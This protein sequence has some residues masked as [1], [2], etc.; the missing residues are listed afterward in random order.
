MN[1]PLFVAGRYLVSRRKKNFINI[2]SLL[3]L[4]GVAFSTA[5]LII[6]LSIFN[7]LES[8]LRSLNNSFDPEIKIE[9]KW[10][11]SFVVTDSLLAAIRQVEGVEFV[12]EVIE[13]YVYLRYRDANQ[14]VTMKGVSEDFLEQHRIDDKIVAGKL[15]LKEQDV[16]YAIIGRGIQYNL[17]VAI[18]DNQ[19]ALQVYY[20]NNVRT[21][22]VDPSK[23]YSRKSIFAGAAFSIVQNFDENYIVVPLDFA[24]ELLNMGQRRTALEVKTKAGMDEA[25]VHAELKARLGEKFSVLNHEEQHKDLYRLLKME[26]LFTFLAFAVLLGIS[27][28]NIFFTLM[29]LA[30]DKK[31][32]ISVLAAMGAPRQLIR[33]IFLT[34][35][36]IIA[37]LGAFAGLVLGAVFCW[38][39]SRYGIISMGMETSV[40]E[41]YP[42]K[43]IPMD[44]VNT[45][46]VVSM[47]TVLIS[48]RPAVLASRFA[49]VRN[50]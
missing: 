50:L 12:T 10:G 32:D 8:L 1:F 17:S 35:G 25:R 48:W 41:G 18:D 6:V 34:E 4:A 23:L 36:A 11:K 31:K 13:D 37:F 39:Q 49:S 15:R 28:I 24:R 14:V 30:I 42:V 40:T 27:S 26:K 16:N 20:I 5:A 44:F 22:I 7:G 33:S 21:G 46:L 19:F 45:L 47:L 43:I 38:I 29:M 2:I 9:A 3:S